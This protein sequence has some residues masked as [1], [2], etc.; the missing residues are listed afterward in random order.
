MRREWGRETGR[1]KAKKE[2][3][4]ERVINGVIK[5]GQRG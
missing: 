5:V 3:I 2:Y 4:N 1:E